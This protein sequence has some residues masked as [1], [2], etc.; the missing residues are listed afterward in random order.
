MTTE[1]ENPRPAWFVGAAFGGVDD[2]TERFIQDGIWEGGPVERYGDSVASIQPG[3]RIA[4][5]SWF[6]RKNGLRFDN[7][8]EFVSVMAIKATGVVVE[9]LG[10][11]RSL[12]VDWTPI[13]PPR[14][15]YFYT[16]NGTVWQ[17]PANTRWQQ[18]LIRSTFDG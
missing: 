3:D 12:R 8:G 2:Q 11:R 4:I 7:R 14:E 17:V 15:W 16:F 10:N 9:N 6:T 18:A 5:K 13:D 1:S